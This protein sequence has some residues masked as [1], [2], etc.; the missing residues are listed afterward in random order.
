[1]VIRR[2]TWRIFA[3]NHRS[4]NHPCFKLFNRKNWTQM[5][6]E[7]KLAVF[8]SSHSSTSTIDHLGE[9][10]KTLDPNAQKITDIKLQRTK[11]TRLQKYVITPEF[12]KELICD[13]GNSHF[14]LIIEES[15]NV[16][17]RACLGICIRY[18]SSKN[19][20]IIDSFYR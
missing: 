7:L 4:D 14:S 10:V 19:N 5:V 1:M 17:K 3:S 13:I 8:I 20:D 6:N 12:L 2:S 15:T 9:L 16:A 11:F 18:F